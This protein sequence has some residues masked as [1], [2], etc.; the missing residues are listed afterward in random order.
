MLNM[1][2]PVREVPTTALRNHQLRM[3]GKFLKGPIP[4]REIAEA[5]KLPGQALG[6]YLAIHHRATLTGSTSVTLPRSLLEQ[7]GVSRDSKARSLHALEKATLVSVER[8]KGRTARI[9]LPASARHTS[10]GG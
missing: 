3:Q 10:I 2:I 9:T 1:I 4:L 8:R 7:F 5:S 6:V